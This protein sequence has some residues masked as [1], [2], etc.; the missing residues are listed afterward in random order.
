MTTRQHGA[1]LGRRALTS[2]LWA[3]A[4]RAGRA[5]AQVLF[6]IALGRSVGPPG[7][8]AA[9]IAL[10]GYQLTSTLAAQSFAQALVRYSDPDPER[11]ATAFWLNMALVAAVTVAGAAL[12]A[13]VARWL[14]LPDLTWLLP[15]L[16]AMGLIAA[17]TVLAQARLS[18]EMDFRRIAAIET[19]SSLV[20]AAAGIAAALMGTGL[21]ALV[22]YGGVQRL[23]ETL[24]FLR[25]GGAWPRARPGRA[26]GEL[27]RFTLPLAGLQ[28]AAFANSNV[29]QFFVGQ[30]GNARALG[31]YALARRFSQQPTRMI[32]FAINRAIYPAMVH[33][34]DGS[35]AQVRLF[36][37]G[38]RISVLTASL[39]LFLL[40]AVAGEF[41]DLA[42]GPGWADAAPY[43]ALFATTSAVLPVGGVLSAS[44]RA[45]GLTGIQLVF[46][47]LRLGV[48]MIVLGLMAAAGAGTWPMAVAVALIAVASLAPPLG[49]AAR[50]HGV[51]LRMAAG[52]LAAGLAPAAAAGAAALLLQ[53]TL[54]AG[55]GMAAAMAAKGAVFALA[56]AAAFAIEMRMNGKGRP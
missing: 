17:P 8:A 46:Q 56:A 51:A 35:G 34:R 16:T 39:P 50:I 4:G 12:G 29:D 30:A 3:G 13:P 36:L 20:A 27:L 22:I 31:F 7:F 18:R 41:L 15:L 9:S 45:E 26:A 52:H 1:S 14:G 25:E 32:T 21:V 6:M 43:L 40:A 37:N 5:A 49:E 44:L 47:L 33:A 48:T 11:D 53:A 2:T 24:C 23:V 28:V 10:I 38:V 54:L 55:A 19:V 42:M